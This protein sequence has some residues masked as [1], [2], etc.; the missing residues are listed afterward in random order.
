MGVIK[1]FITATWID[2]SWFWSTYVYLW[3][4]DFI[5]VKIAQW[6]SLETSVVPKIMQRIIPP[7]FQTVNSNTDEKIMNAELG[8]DFVMVD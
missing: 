6:Y 7:I 2:K 3:M 4:Y 8:M 1:D 5:H